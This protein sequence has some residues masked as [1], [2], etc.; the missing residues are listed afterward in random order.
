MNNQEIL[1]EMEEQSGEDDA[2]DDASFGAL[3][4]DYTTQE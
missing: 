3:D 1:S 2:Y 4:V